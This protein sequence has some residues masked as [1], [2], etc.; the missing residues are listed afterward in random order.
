MKN[1][2]HDLEAQYIHQKA[3][4]SRE[5][6][7]SLKL[8]ALS[9]TLEL[10]CLGLSLQVANNPLD[11]PCKRKNKKEKT[12]SAMSKCVHEGRCVAHRPRLR[13]ARSQAGEMKRMWQ[14]PQQL[15]GHLWRFLRTLHACQSGF[16][17]RSEYWERTA[18]GL[19]GSEH[20]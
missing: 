7:V 2:S 12:V 19:T 5:G 9:S 16:G 18:A 11:S 14:E 17:N 6:R 1:Y 8:P 15:P 3:H 13:K 4:A 20:T 10:C